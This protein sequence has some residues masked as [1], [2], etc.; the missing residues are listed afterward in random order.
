MLPIFW[1]SGRLW[2]QSFCSLFAINFRP[3]L[4]CLS[5]YFYI[6]PYA[7]L[8]LELSLCCIGCI[9]GYLNYDYYAFDTIEYAGS[10]LNCA[11]WR[12][13][14]YNIF[15]RGTNATL[16]IRVP[17]GANVR[18]LVHQLERQHEVLRRCGEERLVFSLLFLGRDLAL[19]PTQDL[20][21]AGLVDCSTIHL[22]Y[23]LLGGARLRG[24]SSHTQLDPPPIEPNA[25]AG[26]SQPR[27]AVSIV[28]C[29]KCGRE[30]GSQ[31]KLHIHQGRDPDCNRDANDL[32]D[33]AVRTQRAR[34]ALASRR[35]KHLARKLARQASTATSHP[36]PEPTPPN[37]PAPNA[38]E[39][40][41][42]LLDSAAPFLPPHAADPEPMDVDHPLEPEVR[43]EEPGVHFDIDQPDISIGNSE[44]GDADAPLGWALVDRARAR[45]VGQAARGRVDA[46]FAEE[47][48]EE[49]EDEDGWE[50]MGGWETDDGDDTDDGQEEEDSEE[51]PIANDDADLGEGSDDD[52]DWE[53]IP[54]PPP[55]PS[56]S[57]SPHP[58]PTPPPGGNLPPPPL[59]DPPDPPSPDGTPPPGGDHPPPPEDE[60]DFPP[61]PEDEDT[62]EPPGRRV[63]PF[64][65]RAGEPINGDEPPGDPYSQY[66]A[67]LPN[68]GDPSNA[69][70]PFESKLNWD[71]AAWAKTHS[72]GSNAFTDLLKIEGLV[73]QLGIQFKSTR[74]LHN[75]MD[76]ALPAR[77]AFTRRTYKLGSEELHLYMRNSLDIVKELFSRPEFATSLVFAPERH[78]VM[79][80]E[81]E[82]RAYSDMHT[83]KWWWKMQ[84]RLE[85]RKP[86]A[87]I[88]PLILSSDKTQLTLFR[89]RSAYPVYLT[90]GNLP[91]ELCRKTSL[92]GQILVGYLPVTKFL[93][94]K[95]DD[96]L[97]DV[98]RDG[99]ILTSGDGVQRRCHPLLAAFVGDYPEQV[100]VTGTKYGLC[101]KGTLDR[102][103]F[104]F[105]DKC[106][107]QDI[108]A[109]TEALHTPHDTDVQA[110]DFVARCQAAG[111][112]PIRTFWQD[113]PDSNIFQAIQPDIL[114]QL[115]QGVVKHL[116]AWLRAVYGDKALDARFQ[117]LPANH[118][119]RLFT[120]GISGLSRVT[121]SEH[122][123]ICRVLLGVIIDAPL[124]RSRNPHR[125]A[126]V[127]RAVRALLDF[128]YLVQYPEASE[129]TLR[130]I[131]KALRAFHNN[132][133]VFIDLKAREHFNF[134]KL[135]AIAHY[136]DSIRLFGTADNFN[137]SYSERLHI[138]FAKS[139]YRASN[140][141]DEYPQMT[142][143]LQR[144]EQI[145]AHQSYVYWRLHG[146]PTLEDLP[147]APLPRAPKLK[148]KIARTPNRSVNFADADRLY[149]AEDFESV[150]KQY[151]LKIKLPTLSDQHIADIAATAY[152][153]PFTSVCA[154]HRL[155][156]WHTDALEREG[157]WVQELP[158]SIL[159]RPAYRDAQRRKV[160]GQYS[161]ALIDEYG[162]GGSNGVTGYRVGQVR[163]IFA[164]T[165]TARKKTFNDPTGI[166]THFA[167]I[168]WFSSF[169][170]RGPDKR[171]NMYR[172]DRSVRDGERVVSILPID[173]IRRSVSLT[174]KFGAKWL[175]RGKTR[176]ASPNLAARL[177][178]LFLNT[179]HHHNN[180]EITGFSSFGLSLGRVLF[181]CRDSV[182]DI[183]ASVKMA[184]PPAPAIG[185]APAAPAR[186]LPRFKKKTAEQKAAEEKEAEA[187]KASQEQWFPSSS[188][189]M[190]HPKSAPSSERSSQRSAPPPPASPPQPSAEPTP[191]A[192]LQPAP[193]PL[194]RPPQDFSAA[195]RW[196]ELVVLAYGTTYIPPNAHG[197]RMVGHVHRDARWG[198]F[199]FCLHP[200]PNDRS[201]AHMACIPVP[202]N[203]RTVND[204]LP[205]RAPTKEDLEEALHRHPDL[206]DVYNDGIPSASDC[207]CRWDV[208]EQLIPRVNALR[209]QF[210][211]ATRLLASALVTDSLSGLHLEVAKDLVI[212]T[213]AALDMRKAWGLLR[214]GRIRSFADFAVCWEA[215][216]R[217]SCEVEGFILLCTG[218]L[219]E[220]DDDDTKA[221]LR[222]Q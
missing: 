13:S 204:T 69:Y 94:V 28:Q 132:K 93:G 38:I 99:V 64:G 138:D 51:E 50:R 39:P 25:E 195:A 110:A 7:L 190:R 114:H 67:G 211:T 62:P 221:W 152:T 111:V 45:R 189:R 127:I 58:S 210:A 21:E 180:I 160:Q 150:L 218:L 141:K 163:L 97:R 49:V 156:F 203:R 128:V 173:R 75:V 181:R 165:E 187:A 192:Q 117:C 172:V 73:D 158:D 196:G 85:R 166:P 81:V 52:A 208:H 2:A 18:W 162:E 219:R 83:G 19:R 121:G 178:L 217:F 5:P 23:H 216:R 31:R 44:E 202:P 1:V 220:V 65:R 104:G 147:R 149:G 113:Y 133:N 16:L 35:E 161:T 55:P 34:G 27:T 188:S 70:H 48:D 136:Y 4:A 213:A 145:Q 151:V 6:L 176:L 206:E 82:E 191:S 84:L 122:Q 212:P 37:S 80:G 33:A 205:F 146:R 8:F 126:R 123:D 60:D 118:Q 124:R 90:I 115:Y 89:N 78:Y 29:I 182:V 157:E 142:V 108:A 143:W 102:S 72:I 184:N 214:Y 194:R 11:Q 116:I 98:A 79:V 177:A 57:P 101:P 88:I 112:K 56:P 22:R 76:N 119:L 185:A 155:K 10:L 168:E 105:Q 107:P 40:E 164:L 222:A 36:E 87:T 47:E 199:D 77:P 74:D 59:P 96:P 170:A 66:E 134:P 106:K 209:D 207:V 153:L 100:L 144:R 197:R 42:M 92:H 32:R 148:R 26:P 63:V 174:P 183:P 200:Q 103:R 41:P 193:A 135:H 215:F 159:A 137:T 53:D 15:V 17:P 167:Y 14:E 3:L 179:H 20:R 120:K 198:I 61:P 154:Y 130:D 139:A 131:Q 91:K 24:S 54:W 129:S 68:A 175:R 186:K 86:G 109:A 9:F 30:Y 71:I 171:G 125:A 95:D 201:S 12:H 169:P 46:E 43:N 140:R